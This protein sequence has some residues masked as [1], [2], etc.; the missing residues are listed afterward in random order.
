MNDLTYLIKKVGN[1]KFPKDIDPYDFTLNSPEVFYHLKES[2]QEVV[3][4]LVNTLEMM[5]FDQDGNLN[6]RD[7]KQ[8]YYAGVTEIWPADDNLFGVKIPAK[9]G[10]QGD[11]THTIYFAPVSI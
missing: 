1:I 6:K 4:D 5:E 7:R 8:L 2:E 11:N 10:Y 9:D 3:S